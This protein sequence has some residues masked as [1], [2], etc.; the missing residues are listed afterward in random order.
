[1]NNM[2][3]PAMKTLAVNAWEKVAT[4]V[5][6]GSI[7]R[8]STNPNKYL[9]TYRMTGGTP[10][11]DSSEGVEMFL[12]GN[13]EQIAAAAGIDVYIMAVGTNGRIRVDVP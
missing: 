9:E 12:N 5:T 8:F 2:A 3:N 11:T 4:N 1:M 7:K 6:A 10:P 13:S